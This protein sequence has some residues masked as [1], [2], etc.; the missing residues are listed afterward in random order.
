MSA[1]EASTGQGP[2]FIDAVPI[3]GGR[4]EAMS[5][6]FYCRFLGFEVDFEF[7]YAPELPLYLG[8]ER[9][10]LHLHVDHHD[11]VPGGSFVLFWLSG[12]DAW[13]EELLTR[14]KGFTVP[15]ISNQ[16]WGRE[17]TVTDP[18]GNVLRFCEPP[19]GS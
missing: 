15:E 19:G 13:R 17:M 18:L 9:G 6:A 11:N 8:L 1:A 2:R 7:R 5:R 16:P 4:D 14:G 12:I 10:P 3:L